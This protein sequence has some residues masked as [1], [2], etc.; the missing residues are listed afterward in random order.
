[1]RYTGI[2]S[3]TICYAC[4]KPGSRQF[5]CINKP[6]NEKGYNS[7][8]SRWCDKCKT[9]IHDTKYCRKGSNKFYNHN[10]KV[11]KPEPDYDDDSFILECLYVKS[12]IFIR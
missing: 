9:R 1:M 6:K 3:V 11:K 4:G 8:Q 2:Y 10:V 12:T 7:K 5:K